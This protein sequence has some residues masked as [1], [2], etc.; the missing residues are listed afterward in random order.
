M[1]E[2]TKTPCVEIEVTG[3]RKFPRV[4]KVTLFEEDK[5][6]MVLLDICG[7]KFD[8]WIP[9]N[10]PLLNYHH[11]RDN[12]VVVKDTPR[13][14][15]DKQ[16]LIILDASANTIIPL[17]FETTTTNRKGTF[18]AERKLANPIH[19]GTLNSVYLEK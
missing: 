14:I 2:R 18:Y 12:G 16:C 6:Q 13:K 10:E 1:S 11:M 17:V 3:S 5:V 15:G 8:R 7:S 9:H 19:G 4:D